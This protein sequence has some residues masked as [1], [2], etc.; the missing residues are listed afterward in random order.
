MS[1]DEY[2]LL[3]YKELKGEITSDEAAALQT[4][5]DSDVDNKKTYED[6]EKAWSGSLISDAEMEADLKSLHQKMGKD[7]ARGVKLW[8]MVFRVAALLLVVSTTTLFIY[9]RIYKNDQQVFAAEDLEMNLPDGTV[10]QLMEGSTINFK[11]NFLKSR[12]V[13]LAG[14]AYF[15]VQS[16]KENPFTVQASETIIEVVGTEFTVDD[17]KSRVVVSVNEGV[18]RVANK[19]KEVILE[20]GDVGI[21]TLDL[22]LTKQ[23]MNTDN[24][25]FWINDQFRFENERLADIIEQ[26][27]LIFD[28]NINLANKEMDDCS[29]SAVINGEV[30]DLILKSIAERFDLEIKEDSLNIF[31]LLNGQCN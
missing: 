27:S 23:T 24:F 3:I 2:I 7:K 9:Q 16:D 1:Q 11:R 31:T 4:F 15:E 17:S 28:I 30:A 14:K 12:H 19:E 25:N 18:V 6:I 21:S 5:K 29:V 13:D 22:N 8:P 20:Q 26:L 10:V